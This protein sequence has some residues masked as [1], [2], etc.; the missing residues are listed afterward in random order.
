MLN[1]ATFF[2]SRVLDSDLEFPNKPAW[3]SYSGANPTNLLMWRTS[4]GERKKKFKCKVQK[5][6]DL[7]FLLGVFVETILSQASLVISRISN[8]EL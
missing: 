3:I 2:S 4:P 7:I 5:L 8:V 6:D 1:I